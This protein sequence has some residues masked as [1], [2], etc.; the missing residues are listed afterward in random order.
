M[1]ATADLGITNVTSTVVATRGERLMLVRG[2]YSRLDQGS[3]AFVTEVLNLFETNA[4]DQIAAS[5]V[6]GFDELDAALD[7]LDA[8]YLGGEAAPH[9]HT[10]SVITEAYAVLNRH[11]LPATTPDWVNIDHRR[12]TSFAPGDMTDNMRALWDQTP[13]F[14]IYIETVHLLSNRGAVVTH[15]AKGTS[16]EGFDAEW[17]AIDIT[18]VEGDLINRAE[19][20]DEADIGVALARFDELS[21]ASRPLENAASQV[22]E[23]FV[24]VLRGPR[25]GRHGPGDGGRLLQR[26]PPSHRGRRSPTR[27]RCRDRKLAGDGRRRVHERNVDRHCDAGPAAGPYARAYLGPRAGA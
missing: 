27:S 22:E 8:R 9:A 4:D 26:R 11:E 10:W 5:V 18:T 7:E 24:Y 3:D 20:F 25:F 6:F 2:L 16:Q 12:G 21:P 13:D 23:R 17:R 15:T 1:R 19:I 14:S